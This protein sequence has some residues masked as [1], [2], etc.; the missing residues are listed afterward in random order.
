MPLSD[1]ITEYELLQA[2]ADEASET[3]LSIGRPKRH[4]EHSLA[5]SLWQKAIRRGDV[6]WALH[7]ALC[8]YEHDPEYVWRRIRIIALE[9]ISVA[10]LDLVARVLAIAGKR[11]LR[12]KIGERSLLAYLTTTLALAKKCRT[13]CDLASWLEPISEAEISVPL[14]GS[15]KNALLEGGLEA[16]LSSARLWRSVTP[17]SARIDGRWW[18]IG[19]N[20]RQRR[21][22]LLDGISASPLL[23]FVA[24]R[25]GGA[26]A[27][28][29]LCVPA[30]QLAA[31]RAVHRQPTAPP[32][33]SEEL[34]GGIPAYAYCMYS[35][36]GRDALRRFV[37]STNWRE[38]RRWGV[39]K[40]LLQVLGNLVFYVE[41]G[42][43]TE[44]LEVALGP[45]IER[46]SERAL[47]GR[48]GVR[49]ED[50]PSLLQAI[51]DLLPCI[52]AMRRLT[53]PA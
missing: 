43:C 45:E 24:N 11:V 33:C 10:D 3:R 44:V 22:E 36:P 31:I 32:L 42:F 12:A 50:V 16:I 25:G 34:V 49:T 9:D 30:A 13:P 2:I 1:R 35:A 46:A 26:Y 15:E 29:T 19:R 51:R 41:G 20:S 8:L 17:Q 48:L 27:L 23:R 6:D 5:T 47:L 38:A 39:R 52:N 40:N 14:L 18:A 37:R 21:N 4:I 28:N 7:A 53:A